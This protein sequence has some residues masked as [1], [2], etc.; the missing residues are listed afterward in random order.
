MAGKKNFF[1][2]W[3]NKRDIIAIGM[4]IC[5]IIAYL[6]VT[7]SWHI[8]MKSRLDLSRL[9]ISTMTLKQHFAQ[10]TSEKEISR[11]IGTMFNELKFATGQVKL[12]KTPEKKPIHLTEILPEYPVLSVLSGFDPFPD[13]YILIPHKKI[14]Y[15]NDALPPDTPPPELRFI[16]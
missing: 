9:V 5:F 14:F 3:M 12:H 6:P 2:V 1:L 16:S 10:K 15:Q 8:S 4:M 7:G 11:S 13:F